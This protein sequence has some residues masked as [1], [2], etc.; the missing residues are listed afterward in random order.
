MAKN[1]KQEASTAAERIRIPREIGSVG[2]YKPKTLL[3]SDISRDLDF[4]KSIETFRDMSDDITIAS[5]ISAVQVVSSRIPI[6]VEAYDQSEEHKEKQ[7]FLESCFEDMEHS[8]QDAIKQIMTFRTYG[9]SVVEKVYRFRRRKKGSKHDDNKIGIKKLAFRPQHTITEFRMSEDNRDFLGVVQG[10][11]QASHSI[12]DRRIPL[13][14]NND[15]ECFIPK[16]RMLLFVTDNTTGLPYGRSPLVS[17]YQ[18]WR[19][20]QKI[21]DLEYVAMSK[22]L[23]GLPLATLPARF[24]TVDADEDEVDTRMSIIDGISKVGIGEQSSFVLPSD[25]DEQGNP[26]F[27]LKLLQASS[28]NVTSISAIVSRLKKDMKDLFFNDLTDDGTGTLLNMLVES[29]IKDIFD[30]INRDLIPELWEMNGWDITKTPKLRYGSLKEVNMADFAK[31]IQQL[32]A[33]KNI[34]KTPDNLNVIAEI[35]GLPFRFSADATKEEIDEILRVEE[36][37]DSRS[38]DG[39]EKGSGNGTSNKVSEKD[40]SANNLSNK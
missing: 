16:D 19:D 35:M 9:F 12:Y 27:D 3:F 38:G 29:C 34:A 23:N 28:S 4:P 11:F 17:C 36:K 37:D 21:Q 7:K 32:S 25:R 10:E 15:D 33:T 8:L 40:N 24:L 30:V 22:N 39:Y 26:L 20:L 2:N 1:I 13:K 6:Y 18:T 14:N 5:A 31:A